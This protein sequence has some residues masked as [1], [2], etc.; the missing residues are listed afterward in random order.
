MD[1]WDRVGLLVS[2]EHGGLRDNALKLK[3]FAKVDSYFS[4]VFHECWALTVFTSEAVD[5]C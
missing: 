3:A 1:I 5:I 2:V 4:A